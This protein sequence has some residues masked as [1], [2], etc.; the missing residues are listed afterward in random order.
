MTKDGIVMPEYLNAAYEGDDL[1]TGDQ[2]RKAVLA[3]REA[4]AMVAD[5]FD[6]EMK[7][8]NYGQ[9]IASRI[10]ARGQQ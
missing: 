9:V 1:F 6:P 2:L 10:R 4:C 7:M 8:S 5:E 3:E